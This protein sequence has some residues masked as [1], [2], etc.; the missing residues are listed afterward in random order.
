[1]KKVGRRRFSG[2]GRGREGGVV[3]RS[4]REEQVV[5]EKEGRVL[6]GAVK[7]VRELR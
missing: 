5:G 6:R 2:R 4:G 1:M 7:M 3:R